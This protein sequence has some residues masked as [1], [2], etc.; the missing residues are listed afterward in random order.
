MSLARHVM[1]HIIMPPSVNWALDYYTVSLGNK[2]IEN[3]ASPRLTH[4]HL[5][6]NYISSIDFDYIYISL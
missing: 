6:S 5:C 3:K 4:L 2:E 1:G